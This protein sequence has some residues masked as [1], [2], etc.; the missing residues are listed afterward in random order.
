ML[1][2]GD[3]VRIKPRPFLGNVSRI[4]MILESIPNDSLYIYQDFSLS[5]PVLVAG[6]VTHVG[7][8]YMKK[9]QS[10]AHAS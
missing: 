8:N 1:S 10:N 4:G 9:L 6:K 5:L 2:I 3:L 7:V